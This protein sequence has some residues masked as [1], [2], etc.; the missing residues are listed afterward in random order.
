MTKF[1]FSILV[2]LIVFVT[3]SIFISCETEDINVT[4]NSEL[5]TNLQNFNNDYKYEL[6]SKNYASKG[7]WGWVATVAATVSGDVIGAATTVSAAS[8]LIVAASIATTPAG[9]TAVAVAA[10]VVGAVGGS[11]VAYQAASSSKKSDKIKRGYLINLHLPSEYNDLSS[12]GILH[13]QMLNECYFGKKTKKEWIAKNMKFANLKN[14]EL[15]F[16]SKSW[17][18]LY[19]NIEEASTKYKSSN[20]DYL[21][22]LDVNK[23]NN[24]LTTEMYNFYKLFLEAYTKSTSFKDMENIVK[25][26]SKT[27]IESNLIK[28]DKRTILFSLEIASKSPY[29][30][31]NK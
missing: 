12:V 13:N 19:A 31:A 11:Y 26:Y 21:V 14:M 3:S 24:Y 2:L 15:L 7:F 8:E 17:K 10:G 22:L 5:L 28:K 1:K 9:G 25:F 6:N 18:K 29:Y 27:V 4:E 30:W 23:K 16:K 20:Y